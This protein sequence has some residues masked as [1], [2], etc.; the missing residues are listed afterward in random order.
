M[1]K[2][3]IINSSTRVKSQFYT[4]KSIYGIG[5]FYSKELLFRLGISKKK[6]FQIKDFN[7]LKTRAL[8]RYIQNFLIIENS[9]RRF[10]ESRHLFFFKI[11]SIRSLRLRWG[12]PIHGQRTRCNARTAKK[13]NLKLLK[14][15]A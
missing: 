7:L 13:L 3:L 14:R 5:K 10:V 12:Y 2:F 6:L 9:C 15:R 4:L 8:K 1:A 11:K